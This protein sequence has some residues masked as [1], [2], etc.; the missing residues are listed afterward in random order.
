MNNLRK[1][2]SAL[3]GILIA[4]LLIAALAPK[5]ARGVAA[6][7][8]QVTNTSANPVPIVDNTANFPFTAQ[9]CAAF[10]A[11]CTLLTC[12]TFD[13]CPLFA[14]FTVPQTTTTGVSV[15][16]LVI[17]Q[18]SAQCDITG[19]VLSAV[20]LTVAPP[21]NN[22]NPGSTGVSSLFPVALVA[23]Q[24]GVIPASPVR[25]DADPNST[26]STQLIF[27]S[28]GTSSAACIVALS[29]HLETN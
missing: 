16:R 25:I 7:F 17:E 2:V 13:G 15:T 19:N 11:N 12:A 14:G 1:A 21:A 10:N 18:A 26:V 23:S 3:G 28:S 8:V 4:A 22:A 5:A 20:R 29:G 27:Q 6:A 9:T 24:I